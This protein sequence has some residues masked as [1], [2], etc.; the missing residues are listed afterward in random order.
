MNPTTRD[1]DFTPA[2]GAHWLTPFYDLAIATFTREKT[3]RRVLVELL[4]P[5]PED[6]ILDVGCGTG[7]LS[8]ELAKTARVVGVDPDAAVLARAKR[9]AEGAG[10]S[11]HFVQ[12][13][14]TAEILPP[15]FK[16]TKIVSSLVLHQTPSAEKR[17]IVETI[18]DLLPPGGVLALADYGRQPGTMQRA[19]FRVMVQGVDG[20]ENTQ[21]NADG[22][23]D[24]ILAQASFEGSSPVQIV[25]TA[26]GAISLWRAARK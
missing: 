3:W 22:V 16:P 26:T 17:R 10:V 14:L 18:R 5:K 6:R 23:I 12:G 4:D 7:S 25:P 1:A 2:L 24:E 21:P 20:V 13:F 8:V 15:N 19:L 9:K 11:P